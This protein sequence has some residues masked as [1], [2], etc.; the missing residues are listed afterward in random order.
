MA[1]ALLWAVAP[2]SDDAPD[3]APDG[4][5]D[6]GPPKPLAVEV[7]GPTEPTVVVVG[8]TAAD[9][10]L[11]TSEAVFEAAPIV[12]V[13]PADDP[14][15]QARAAVTAVDLSAPLLLTIGA[16]TDPVADELTRLGTETVVAFGEEVADWAGEID[17][18]PEVVV[19]PAGEGELPAT[20]LDAPLEDVLVVVGNDPT[21]TAATAT[22][23]S[24]GA[25]VV[26]VAGGDPRADPAAIEALAA[27]PPDRVLAVGKQFGPAEILR[28]RL[29]VAAT[30]VQLPGG[31]QVLFPHRRLAALYGHP[32]APALGVLGEQPLDASVAR[33]RQLAGSYDGLVAQPVVPAFEIIAT[34]ASSAPGPD[35]NYANESSVDELRP[36]VDAAG[37]A[38][39]YVVLDIQPGR[40]D[41]LTQAQRYEELLRQPHVGLA[42]DP[43]W[44]LGPQQRHLEQIGT[45][46]AA[47]VNAV[48]AWLAQLTRTHHLPQKLLLLH[49]F[50][51]RMITHRPL[52]D[53]GHDELAV[54]VHADG[55]GTHAQK[56]ATWGRMLVDPPPGV[57]WGWKNFYDE[58]QPMLTPAETA[59]IQPSVLFVSYQ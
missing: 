55:F 39:V 19:A 5:D 57:W 24:S 48:A 36:W 1:V 2:G 4:E 42:L 49:Q 3:D 37:R 29:D 27:D 51:T 38:G 53:T 45:V 44:R 32:G 58:D 12:V 13:A 46:D 18:G 40:T 31:G 54:L 17:D 7:T 21:A 30:G 11:A 28:R 22:A 25:R 56:L 16:A 59:A 9:L 8:D 14:D 6:A 41:F 26:T 33:A 50:Q 34:V 35:G 23:R 43:E 20:E 15:A 47:E 52:V 10:A